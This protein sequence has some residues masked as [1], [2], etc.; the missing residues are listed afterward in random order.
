MKE[1]CMTCLLSREQLATVATKI[2][3]INS[4]DSVKLMQFFILFEGKGM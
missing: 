1:R 2:L 4:K 3:G